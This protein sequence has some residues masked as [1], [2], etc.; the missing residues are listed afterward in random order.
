MK[1]DY[2]I[3]VDLDG[4]LLTHSL[5]HDEASFEVLRKL[6]L[7]NKVV[8]ATGRPF[9]SSIYYYNLLNL[10]TPIINYNGALVQNPKDNNFK[11]SLVTI[12]RKIVFKLVEDMKEYLDNIF[13][14]I[15][16]TIYL[17]QDKEN[18]I[19]YLHLE[20][21][22]LITGDLNSTLEADPNGAIIIAKLG[23]EEILREYVENT[24]KG[25]LK[26]RFWGSSDFPIAEL[27]SPL[28]NKGSALAKVSRDLNIAKDKIIAL[29]DGDN[30]MEMIDYAAFGIAMANARPDLK[31]IANEVTL[32]VDESGVAHYLK[33]FF[34]IK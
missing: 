23:S 12:D 8:I 34:D 20:G 10:D 5:N 29:G 3:A 2:L 33:N 30:D 25:S 19:P 28:T 31:E 16:D 26:I 21:G 18:V 4:T 14:E 13:C 7:T 17:W 1:K 24:Y 32:S 6:S 22:H 15:E 9:R 11:K 27:Y